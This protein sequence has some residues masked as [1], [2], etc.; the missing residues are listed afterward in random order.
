MSA[1]SIP[2][3]A[4]LTAWVAARTRAPDRLSEIIAGFDTGEIE[5]VPAARRHLI[6]A[7]QPLVLEAFRRRYGFWDAIRR[8]QRSPDRQRSYERRHRL[9]WSGPL[10]GFLASRLTIADM[11]IARIIA[12]EHSRRRRCDLS[13]SEVAA[14]AGV[15]RKTAKRALCRMHTERLISIEERP[16]K[17]RKNLTNIVRVISRAWLCWLD[18]RAKP[19]REPPIGGH[20]VASTDTRTRKLGE[21]DQTTGSLN[22]QNVVAPRHVRPAC[23][24]APRVSETSPTSKTIPPPLAPAASL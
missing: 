18:K 21:Q 7:Q 24:L 17:G 10:P 22:P 20:L 14:R 16:I 1:A 4:E 9:A 3:S 19:T 23:E 5:T 8:P 13:I 15:C 12:D 11:A 6:G 2:I